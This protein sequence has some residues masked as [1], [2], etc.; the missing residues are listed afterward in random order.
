MMVAHKALHDPH[1]VLAVL[2]ETLPEMAEL[3]DVAC[4]LAKDVLIT[5]GLTVWETP[6]S[7]NNILGE[8]LVDLAAPH[9]CKH[10]LFVRNFT[11][12]VNIL[13]TTN[14]EFAIISSRAR[15]CK[16]H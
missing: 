7:L 15:A 10:N 8:H 4:F 5:E 3:P 2:L 6:E 16:Q 14:S 9:H 13:V 11:R 1:L 12:L